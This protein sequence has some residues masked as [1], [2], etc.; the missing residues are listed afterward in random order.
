MNHTPPPHV[1]AR[2]AK[3]VLDLLAVIL[4]RVGEGRPADIALQDVFRSHHEYG[5][6]DRRLFAS[7]IH[8]HFRWKGWTDLAPALPLAARAA[9]AFRLDSPD[10]HPAVDALAPLDNPADPLET[11]AAKAR[12]LAQ[13]MNLD[14]PP[15]PERLVPE[16]VLPHLAWP[17]KTDDAAGRLRL[18]ESLQVRPPT[19]IRVRRGREA[20]VRDC[21]SQLG[22]EPVP[23][24]RLGN[25]WRVNNTAR[26]AD[27]LSRCKGQLEIQDIASQAVGHAADP[28][29]GSAWWDACAG[30]GG[31][32]LHLADLAG[33]KVRILASDV[34]ETTLTEAARR[35]RLAGL[36]REVRF[37]RL[38]VARDSLPKTL[39]DGVLVDA[40][41]SGSGTWAR[42]P[43]ARWRFDAAAIP[44]LAETQRTILLRAADAVK[45][46]G[47]LLYVT[48]SLLAD[49]NAGVLKP[50]MQ[51]RPDFELAPF[52]NPLT[53]A[54]TPGW[55]C[56]WPW[57]GP[58][59]CLFAARFR[60]RA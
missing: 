1:I 12:Q 23:H 17:G 30:A 5:S 49:E 22:I 35:A 4:E 31:K 9:V 50:F 59:S 7:F 3:T 26:L 28:Q 36:D 46:G 10:S 43:D 47:S 13:W 6:R 20:A 55:A 32:S 29:P 51:A 11:L 42:N 16:A 41:C 34:R 21:C 2:Q 45:P 27:L 24:E 60:R 33:G 14:A 39:F 52:P 15:P 54:E 37:A 57:E 25:A 40:P 38:D 56:F 19:W 53:G 44:A 58:G 8:S 18:L 48:C